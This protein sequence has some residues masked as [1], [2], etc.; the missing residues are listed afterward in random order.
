MKSVRAF[1]LYCKEDREYQFDSLC[2]KPFCNRDGDDCCQFAEVEIKP[3]KQKVRR[4][5]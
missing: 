1:I 5:R 4:G 2:H 3:V